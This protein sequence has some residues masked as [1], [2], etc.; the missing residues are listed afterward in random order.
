[1]LPRARS[2]RAWRGGSAAARHQ[3]RCYVL[4]HEVSP[5]R[6]DESGDRGDRV[7]AGAPR[8]RR[9]GGAARRKIRRFRAARARRGEATA[10]CDVHLV[11]R[12]EPSPRDDAICIA[13]ACVS[14]PL[15]VDGIRRAGARP[16]AAGV[17]GVCHVP[18]AP[19]RVLQSGCTWGLA[20]F[21]WEGRGRAGG[22]VSEAMMEAWAA[23]RA[24]GRRRGQEL[25]HRARRHV[26]FGARPH[27]LP[28][29][30]YEDERPPGSLG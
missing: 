11:K 18:R 5:S 17:I 21:A 4:H 6:S 13:E 15:H 26:E 16:R 27:R 2:A 10:P 22:S 12:I 23:F 25:R 20:A 7:A 9:L 8:A 19:V 29:S 24:R 1:M 28:R 14:I 3:G 30:I